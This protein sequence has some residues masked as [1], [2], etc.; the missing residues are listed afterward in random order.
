MKICLIT[1]IPVPYRIPIFENIDKILGNNFLVIYCAK[2]ES[3][4]KWELDN[5]NFN[6]L[7]LKSNSK[8]KKDGFNYVHNNLEIFKHL[9]KFNPDIVI[10]T[11]FNPTHLYAWLY[12]KLFFKKHIPMTDG[13]LYSEKD[14][15]KLHIILRKL[16]FKTSNAYIGASKN[17]VEL[18][19]SYGINGQKVFQSHLC[20]DNEKFKN[21]NSFSNRKYHVMFSGQFTDRKI[22][23][24]FCEIVEKLS[25]RI[26]N[27]KVLILGSGPL[28]IEIL[29]RLDKSKID[30]DYPGFVSQEKLPDFY[31]NSK[32]FLFTT[33]LDAWGVVAN[34]SMASG[35]PII[36]TP[37]AGIIND[38]LIDSKNGYILDIDV[39]KWSQKVETILRNTDLW[40]EL[41]LNAINKVQEFNFK[42]A[43]NGIIEAS[44]FTLRN[45][46]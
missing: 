32:L 16:I 37:Y 45:R 5:F 30:Y 41:S 11:G 7:F 8:A 20:I 39:E 19:K 42:D 1:N 27:F 38:L 44:K 4:R 21:L 31:A 22:P 35:T 14:L 23:F 40:N 9:I 6:Y 28:E 46:L 26:K 12:S 13:W 2:T 10:T 29:N 34:E 17:S 24:F 3:N 43:S 36:S 33:K 18:F 15:S 25:L